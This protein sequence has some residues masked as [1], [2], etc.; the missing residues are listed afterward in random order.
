M[1]THPLSTKNRFAVLSIDEMTELDL[2]S[3]TDSAEN[4][5]EAV[6]QTPSPVQASPMSTPSSFANSR[7]LRFHRRPNWEK[8]L[9]DRFVV[10]SA[11]SDNSL[12]LSITLQTT[13]M[14][15][16][17]ST[18]ALLD[19]GATNKFVHSDFVKRN[20][21]T[22]RLLSGPIPIYNV[23]GT[24]NEAGSIT[25]VVE[26]M[27]QYCDHS[28]KMLFA[29]T[30]LGKQDVILGLTWLREHNPEVD[31]KSGEVKMSRCPNHCRTC[32]NEVN[33]E[34]KERLAEEANIHSCRAG[35]MPKPDVEMED[36]PDLGD[37][38]DDE[39]EE[40]E[41]YAGEDAMEEGDRLFT[42]TI[43]CEAEFIRVLLNI[44]QRL[45]EAFHKNTQPKTF[46]EL[47]PT[48]LQDF[49]DLFAK[50]S[51]DCLPDRK[52]WDHAIELVPDSKASN[53]KVYPLAP[54]EQVKLD[55]FIQE[56]LATG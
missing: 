41:P 36:I 12:E 39:E 9:P 30:G 16:V 24:L 46:H 13:D 17:F 32:Q 42:A 7:N 33:A 35:P 37:V 6:P 19:C 49:E 8:R 1:S 55:E 53:C 26:M 25:E 10:A 29:V 48:Y 22:T 51:F 31:W 54:N 21:I 45:V 40:E 14:G 47:V 2:M 20:R 50:S 3:S 11:I 18:A 38:S 4:D 44:S 27:L 15:E 5:A 56:N 34:R 52:V 28:E 43:P 23:D